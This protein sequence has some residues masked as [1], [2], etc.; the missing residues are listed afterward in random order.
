MGNVFQ[1]I[2]TAQRYDEALQQ[3]SAR[4]SQLS[5]Q[6]EKLTA[7]KRVLRAGDDPVAAAQAERAL[8]RL[9][10]IQSE[11]RALAARRD[12]M[13]LGESALGDAVGLVQNFRELVVGAGNASLSARDRNSIA[14]QLRGLRE[15]LLEAANRR[16][17]NGM[18]LLGALG[19]AV[20]PFI[21]PLG[22][23]SS[24]RFDGLPGQP[25]SSG[26]G[27][28]GALDGDAALIFNPRRDGV[29]QASVS[30]IPGDRQLGASAITPTDL[31]LV[32]GDSYSITFSDV[33][34]GATPGSRSARYTI[35]N[36]STGVASA[37]VLLPDYPADQPLRVTVTGVPGLRFDIVGQPANDDRISLQPSTS[38]FG[39]LDDAIDGIGRAANSQAAAQAVGQAL[40]N[41]DT[42]LE[43]LHQLRSYAGELLNRADRI[44]GEQEKRS[45]ALEDERSQAEDLDMLQ[46]ISD[47]QKQ[48]TGYEAALKSYAKVQK[49]SLFDFMA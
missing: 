31:G 5:V 45:I 35:S 12:A 11:Q 34:P 17:G 33:G 18:P 32:T 1:R 7:G 42:G 24:Y 14:E 29:Y 30:D 2:G 37:P 28:A 38:L 9:S 26:V 13:A 20:T 22:G 46:G 25:A 49:L 27:I 36:N 43:K 44:S 6:Q 8:N 23:A 15:Q 47:F 48:Q 19:G 40:A 4:Q 41:I 39:T 3:L 16:D 21:G 10:R